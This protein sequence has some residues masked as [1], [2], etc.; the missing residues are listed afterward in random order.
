MRHSALA[1]FE[2]VKKATL[3]SIEHAT[4]LSETFPTAVQTK[5]E[6]FFPKFAQIGEQILI[7]AKCYSLQPVVA[8]I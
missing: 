5:F 7:I 2:C 6:L 8:L 1:K 4:T 3:L